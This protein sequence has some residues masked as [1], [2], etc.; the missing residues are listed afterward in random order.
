[1]DVLNIVDDP[2]YFIFDE[3]LREVVLAFSRDTYVRE[4]SSYEIYRIVSEELTMPSAVQ[5]FL[6]LAC[7][8]APLGYVIRRGPAFYSL[9]REIYCQLWC[10]MTVLSGDTGTLLHV[11]KTFES[12]LLEAHPR[13]F[14][15]LVNI[16]IQPLQ[17][18]FQ[19]IQLGYV[20]FLEVDQLLLLWDRI[21]GYNDTSLLAVF[22]A[23][24]FVFRAESLLSCNS[25]EFAERM[26]REFSRVKVIP[27]LQIF[28]MSNNPSPSSTTS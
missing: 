3:T 9:S 4:N 14:L 1:M 11:C 5:P 13:L 24:V 18:A 21:L 2:N 19:W 16:G 15:H 25:P 28:F 7:Y 10:K 27:L 20:G 6:G 22:A 12:L 26:L 8:F 17:I 23:A